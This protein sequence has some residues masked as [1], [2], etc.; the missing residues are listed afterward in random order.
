MA[1]KQKLAR[2]ALTMLALLLST[3]IAMAQ[4][5]LKLQF[6]FEHVSGQS[7]TDPIS[8][9][10]AQLMNQAKVVD[11]GKYHVL[12]LGN[13]TGYL[14]MTKEAGTI[15]KNLNDFTVSVYYRVDKDASLSGAGYFLWCFSQSEANTQ[16]ASP[17]MG[18]RL[19]AQR[20]ATSTGGWGSEVGTQVGNASTKGQWIHMLYR[21]TR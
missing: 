17:Y 11:Y 2:Y 3:S 19:N 14:D 1:N 7:V 20:M 15:A 8:G 6:N 13:G 18:Y 21:Q 16:T 12:D 4:Q 5:H 9:V 10:T